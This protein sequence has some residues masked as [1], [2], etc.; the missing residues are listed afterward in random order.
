MDFRTVFSYIIFNLFFATAYAQQKEAPI[1]LLNPS[2]EGTPKSGELPAGWMNCGA[3]N[4]TPPDTQPW[5]FKVDKLAQQGNSYLGMVVRDNDSRESVAQRLPTPLKVDYCYTF[6]VWLCK[7]EIYLSRSSTSG[8]EANYATPVKL[9][10]WAGN[11]YCEKAELLAET[12]EV[13]TM[14]WAEYKFEFKPKKDYSYISF[15]A[16]HK[17]PTL[18]S[19]N[20]NILL[21][22]ASVLTPKY[23]GRPIASTTGTKPKPNSNPTKPKPNP[24]STTV[25]SVPTNVPNSYDSGTST[26]TY[27]RRNL[28]VGQTIGIEK[29]YF[30]ADS[31]RL[32]RECIPVL[33]ELYQFMSSNT[34]LAIE[35]GGHTNDIPPDEFCDKLS[36]LRAKAV[37]E[38]L[39][40]KGISDARVKFRGYGK[41][42]PLFPN[43]NTDNRRRN[44]RVEIKILS[45]G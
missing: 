36:S 18:I 2:F 21:D 8:L 23:C 20:G 4:E 11:N 12:S 30:D 26:N 1:K 38:Y 42:Q 9:R 6:S 22:N 16:S 40:N 13:T 45:I 5:Q 24:G 17:T 43:V 41:R 14:N 15:E 29:L 44:Q 31:T 37:A 39:I 10:V 33:D 3:A 27:D 32:K 28:K 34:D 7:S 35:I 19:Y 25:A